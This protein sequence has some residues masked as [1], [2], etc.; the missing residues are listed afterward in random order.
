MDGFYQQLATAGYGYGPSFQ[1]VRAV[2]RRGEQVFAEVA[3]PTDATDAGFGIHP[4]LLDAT[5]H[6][7][8]LLTALNSNGNGNGNGDAEGG[9]GL[10][11]AWSGVSLHAVGASVLRVR[12]TP[13]GTGGITVLAADTDGRP[14]LSIDTLVSRPIDPHQLHTTTTGGAG[15][16]R[17]DWTPTPTPAIGQDLAADTAGWVVWGTPDDRPAV[18]LAT[19]GI[20][21]GVAAELSEVGGDTR[22]VVVSPVRDTVLGLAGDS[23]TD[24]AGRVRQATHRVL[25]LVQA[26]LAEDRLADA[27]LLLVTQGAV[28]AGAGEQVTDLAA[29][30][31]WGLVK[32]AQAEHPGRFLLADIDDQPGS[33]PQ[34]GTAVHQAVHQDEP[35]LCL[36]QGRIYLPRLTR[37]GNADTPVLEDGP[38]ATAGTVLV[39]GGTGALGAL[40]AR[41][42]VV[43]HRVRDLV[44]VSRRGPQ[45]PGWP[46]WRRS[47]PRG[48]PGA[49]G[50]V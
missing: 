39:T 9:V 23:Q 44:L 22:V 5:L 25:E 31:V 15:L 35:Q 46:S 1:G 41:H 13:D 28:A 18:S 50:R 38:W 10:P 19:A 49:G 7:A 2:W 16:Y 6:P 33:W 26:W 12:L 32:S 40:V 27:R 29:A 48:C 17:L 34:L 45:R 37:A 42:L 43:G 4:A 11:F 47:W 3:L 20:P 30:A 14:V 24:T 36:R 8:G 21:V